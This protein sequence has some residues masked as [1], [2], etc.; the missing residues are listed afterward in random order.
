MKKTV[1]INIGGIIF[2]IEEDGFD[3]L[4]EYLESVNK[5][6]S[7][8]D[9]SA[10]IISDIEGRIAELFLLKLTDGRQTLNQEDVT[11]LI[12]TMGTTQDFEASIEDDEK[13]P[14]KEPKSND[15]ASSVESESQQ[16]ATS[17]DAPKRLYRDT[18]KGILGGVAA[19]IAHYLN[20]DALWIRLLFLALLIN[21]FFYGLSA[22]MFIGYIILWVAVPPS[23]KLVENKNIKKLYRNP[24][25][26]V[27]G[28][29]GSGLAAYFGV[30]TVVIRL[31]FVLTIFI[32]GSG[33][34]AYIILWIITPEAKTI[35]D[36]MQM[37]GKPVTLR[38]IE[39]NVKKSLKV[40]DGEEESPLVKVL[41]FPFRLISIL[42]TGIG[43]VLGPFLSFLVDVIRVGFGAILVFIGFSTVASLLILT[44]STLGYG[45]FA[46]NMIHSDIPIAQIIASVDIWVILSIFLV[47]FIPSIAIALLGLVIILKRRVVN[48][49]VGWSLF[50][51]WIAGILT[52]S[53]TIPKFVVS[54]KEDSSIK[55]EINFPVEAEKTTLRLNDLGD[56]DF[57][58]VELKLRGHSDSTYTAL[59]ETSSRGR[60]H[61]EAKD[62]A[63]MVDYFV[64]GESGD[65]IF[66]S[67]MTFDST[68]IFRFQSVE[69][70]FYIPYNQVFIIDEDLAEILRNTVNRYGYRD[71]DIDG[72]E[73][74]FLESGQLECVTCK[75]TSYKRNDDESSVDIQREERSYE[76]KTELVYPFENFDELKV[77]G[78]IDIEVIKSDDY[79]FEVEVAGSER[80]LD[81][82]NVSQIGDLLVVEFKT[83]NWK[84]LKNDEEERV[85][86]KVKMPNLAKLAVSG[87][88]EG[89][90][91]GFEEKYADITASGIADIYFNAEADDL[92]IVMSGDSKL[93]LR[94]KGEILEAVLTGSSSL[95]GLNF[96]VNEADI[97]SSGAA[98]AEISAKN[99]IN[100]TASGMSVIRYIGADKVT[101]DKSGAGKV[102]AY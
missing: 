91:K 46:D 59:I 32:G 35:T 40:K 80:H 24:E 14:E 37:S 54:F 47:S 33:I 101:I 18:K 20:I 100:A 57:E 76:D 50:A 12:A 55:K 9:D 30:D 52:A 77:D 4:K 68:D 10:E 65:F 93:K 5:Y 19:G 31:L 60:D 39:D 66:D 98:K 75:R 79:T 72:N 11:D 43:K 25:S 88:V 45:S 16:E 7:K 58:Q 83:E 69:V 51:L 94:G 41:L 96:M 62:N 6:F 36:K 48:N 34:L 53:F 38:N 102:E 49:Y 70:T 97:E 13:D 44:L 67:R 29:V 95:K 82:V 17:E 22:A 90:I 21:V 73:W 99:S 61:N 85:K 2:H 78:L 3:K 71:G 42:L 56:N 23:N 84:S 81:G 86:L 26:R 74:V 8:F 64:K 15:E 87:A 28:G 89:E 27:L 1:S 92:K 63:A